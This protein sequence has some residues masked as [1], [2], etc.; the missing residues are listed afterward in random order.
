M[1]EMPVSPHRYVCLGHARMQELSPGRGEGSTVG[2]VMGPLCTV[3][4]SETREWGGQEAP[5]RSLLSCWGS[6]R[7]F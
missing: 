7:D 4:S 3:G 6:G 2:A 1:D 5:H